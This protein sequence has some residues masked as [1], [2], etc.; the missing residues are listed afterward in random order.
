MTLTQDEKRYGACAKA[1]RL[2]NENFPDL[3]TRYTDR[4]IDACL[5][6]D[7]W[8]IRVADRIENESVSS[9]D[10][11]HDVGGLSDRD[12]EHFLPRI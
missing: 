3:Y 8:C 1:I 11:A 2:I 10:I 4:I 5:D 12:D 9:S 7:E 6:N